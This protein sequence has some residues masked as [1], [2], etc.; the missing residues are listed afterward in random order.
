[1]TPSAIPSTPPAVSVEAQA[2]AAFLQTLTE[3]Q[4]PV[5][6]RWH[7]A[8]ARRTTK[9]Q[10]EHAL[11]GIARL[12]CDPEGVYRLTSPHTK[13]EHG[14][15]AVYTVNVL[16]GLCDCLD[17]Q[18]HVARANEELA[19]V[20][21]EASFCC[22]HIPICVE[23]VAA[24]CLESDALPT[25]ESLIQRLLDEAERAGAVPALVSAASA[26]VRDA[27]GIT[28]ETWL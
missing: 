14:R 9:A 4:R 8:S 15:P 25:T 26:P 19:A 6:L 2:A 11:Y 22:C 21:L 12:D 3:E 24:G 23:K 10:F 17:S 27:G 18:T 16:T 1:M 20:G 28:K 5:F 7:V 13:D